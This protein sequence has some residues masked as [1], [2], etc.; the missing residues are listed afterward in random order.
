MEENR[1]NAAK[2]VEGTKIGAIAVN[3][4]DYEDRI[5][6]ECFD[7]HGSDHWASWAVPAWDEQG[8]PE[9]AGPFS[10]AEEADEALRRY[11]SMWSSDDYD[12]YAE[13]R[14]EQRFGA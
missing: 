8:A 4:A 14:T 1:A 3:T 13:E 9:L 10:T 11:R 6:I 5:V 2:I 7:Y 12:L